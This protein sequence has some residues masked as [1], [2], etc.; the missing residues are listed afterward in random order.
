MMNTDFGDAHDRHMNDA[1]ILRAAFRLA[2]ADHLYGLAAECGLKR[3]MQA[4]GMIL[5]PDGK[6]SEK[7][8]I[9]HM[10]KI[11]P[12]YESYRSGHLQGAAYPL[13]ATNPFADWD[14][15]QRYANQGAFDQ[16]RVDG[17]RQGAQIVQA[18]LVKAQ[19]DGLI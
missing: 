2:N 9:V 13:S 18:L 17:H 14:V 19:R 1:E 12:R 16:Q 7:Q 5:K 6:P 15:H 11:W 4:F 3:L 10:N 8:D